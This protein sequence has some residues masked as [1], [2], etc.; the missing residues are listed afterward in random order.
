[1]NQPF[2]KLIEGQKYVVAPQNDQDIQYKNISIKLAQVQF[3]SP[4]VTNLTDADP[5]K[6][7]LHDISGTN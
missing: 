7:R 3:V 2:V 5:G 1:M 6:S 4:D